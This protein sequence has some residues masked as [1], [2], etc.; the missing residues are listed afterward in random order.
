MAKNTDD[1][2]HSNSKKTV[3]TPALI[4]SASAVKEDPCLIIEAV[5]T[6]HGT[7]F[8]TIHAILRQEQGLEKKLLSLSAAALLPCRTPVL[9]WMR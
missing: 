8:S 9:L 4:T 6:A 3:Q 1:Y 5:A 7:F 2:F